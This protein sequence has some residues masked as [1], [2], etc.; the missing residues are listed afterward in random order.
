VLDADATA[1]TGAAGGVA[2]GGG[3]GVAGR[4]L[5]EGTRAADEVPSTGGG[6]GVDARM[7]PGGRPGR[8]GGRDADGSGGGWGLEMG[9]AGITGASV[10]STSTSMSSDL[11]VGSFILRAPDRGWSLL[12]F[13]GDSIAFGA[14][15]GRG[16]PNGRRLPGSG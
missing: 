14:G 11:S 15:H 7:M 13:C 8:G 2:A 3:G 12:R 10:A 6:G 16:D 5:E 1:S 4:G 9:A